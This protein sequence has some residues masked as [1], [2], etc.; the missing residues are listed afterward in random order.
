M[1]VSSSLF[2]SNGQHFWRH[3]TVVK[4]E[5]ECA[6]FGAIVWVLRQM[7]DYI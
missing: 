6:G 1:I 7:R 2:K 4:F 5:I 3:G